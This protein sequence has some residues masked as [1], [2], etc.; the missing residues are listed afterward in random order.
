ML[1][2]PGNSY[3]IRFPILATRPF[4]KGE[5][6]F[7]TIPVN[8]L[9]TVVGEPRAD[10]GLGDRVGGCPCENLL[11]DCAIAQIPCN[12]QERLGILNSAPVVSCYR[13]LFVS[14]RLVVPERYT[15]PHFP[16]LALPR[17]RSEPSHADQQSRSEQRPTE[18]LGIPPLLVFRKSQQKAITMTPPPPTIAQPVREPQRNRMTQSNHSVGDHSEGTRTGAITGPT[19]G[20]GP[21]SA[22]RSTGCSSLNAHA[23]P[24]RSF[25]FP[26]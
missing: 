13:R 4:K 10:A 19:Q 26:A 21:Q 20:A 25:R 11:A 5:R 3:R 8:A 17:C 6:T 15:S 2:L 16:H 23:R 14:A 18:G 24:P 7:V 22:R 9:I 12:E 1:P